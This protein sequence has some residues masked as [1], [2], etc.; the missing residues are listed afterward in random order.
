MMVMAVAVP[1]VVMRARCAEAAPYKGTC[2]LLQGDVEPAEHLESQGI[3]RRE[4]AT[5]EEAYGPVK[6]TKLIAGCIPVGDTIL[7]R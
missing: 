3:A 7:R 4:N 6:V 5:V 1:A 2:H